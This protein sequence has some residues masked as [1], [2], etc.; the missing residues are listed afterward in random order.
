M[1][2][3]L[4]SLTA[5]VA[6]VL[7]SALMFTVPFMQRAHASSGTF[8]QYTYN[9][10]AGSRPYYVYTPAN[11]QVGTAVPMIVM[12]HGCTQNPTDFAN[13][14]QMNA[15]ADQKQF[16][17]VYPQQT[18]TY[19]SS[20][21]WNW[22]Q[23]ADQARGSGEPAIIAGIAQT[24]EQT[25]S[26]WT[27]DSNRVYVAG[28]SAGA[29][30]SVIM[31]ATYP[32][33]F[34]AIGVHSGLEYQAAT[35]LTSATTAQ[36]QGGPSPTQQGQAAYNAM[37]S[38]ARVVP[39]IDFQ[40]Q[41]DYTVYPVNGDQVIQQWMQTDHLA[42]NS[43]YNASFS[44]PSTNTNGQV[45]GGYSY[46]V[47]TWN[48]NSG[49][50]IEEYWKI[51]SMGH[52]WSGGSTSGSYTDP[53]GPS[54][55]NAMYTFFMNH[56]KNGQS[57]TPTPTSTP[58]TTP[59]P[60][61]TP[62]PTPAP[63]HSITLSSLA[64]EDGYIYPNDGVPMGSLAYLQAGSTSLNQAEVSIVSF[65]T[66]KIP[67]GSTIVSAT[68]TLYRYD[69]YYYQGDLDS[70]SADIS[71]LGGF[72]G[73]N[74]LEQADYNASAGQ[75]NVGYFNAVPTQT[76]QATSDSIASSAFPYINLNGHTQFRVHF[77][78]ATN[79]TYQMDVMDFYSGDSAGS[80]VPVLTVQYR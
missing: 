34:A 73:N 74:A 27:I 63:T 25:T 8:T 61:N 69:P 37:G 13:G 56:P 52:A 66:S 43:T 68:L 3:L 49:S 24:V 10:S 12:L 42:S 48:N 46:T 62:T 19:N 11:Y 72:N 58:T 67:A 60:T 38:A 35:S 36:S 79:N 44:S 26:Q 53:K 65:D 29:A 54:A 30:M 16:I 20:S 45:S 64:A 50:E 57:P 4:R 47:Q 21:C 1:S 77:Q 76:N 15:L 17:V 59:T 78:K 22:F 41:S 5:L 6:L 40:G 31:G 32:D 7:M 39:T 28:M 9:G 51:N 23:T 2:K 14:T 75:A 80:Y 55:T 70:I 18:S 71:P 33:I